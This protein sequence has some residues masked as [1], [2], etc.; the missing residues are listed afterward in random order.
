MYEY[1]IKID[2]HPFIEEFADIELIDD[3][4]S[5]IKNINFNKLKIIF[6]SLKYL[7]TFATKM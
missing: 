2:H 7:L 3:T 4:A 5:K 1:K 6:F